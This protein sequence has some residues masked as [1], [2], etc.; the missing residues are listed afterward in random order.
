MDNAETVQIPLIR[1][2]KT[3]GWAGRPLVP[4]TW[5]E[6]YRRLT[7]PPEPPAPPAWINRRVCR[8]RPPLPRLKRKERLNW[9]QWFSDWYSG[10]H[11]L[12]YR[13]RNQGINPNRT[14][15]TARDVINIGVLYM[16]K[17]DQAV[18]LYSSIKALPSAEVPIAWLGKR[19][20]VKT[21]YRIV[22]GRRRD[23]SRGVA[24]LA[25]TTASGI[26]PKFDVK[27]RVE[28]FVDFDG[29]LFEQRPDGLWQETK[30]GYAGGLYAEY[31]NSSDH[32]KSIRP[33]YKPARYDCPTDESTEA[34]TEILGFDLKP[35]YQPITKLL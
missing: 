14:K 5:E 22:Q 21:I 27:D 26:I 19:C 28:F 32:Y 23:P 31:L 11:K 17:G 13:C 12:G 18:F 1:K 10:L 15:I 7:S 35:G 16:Q 2:L 4:E 33:Y 34:K 25:G 30:N 9:H 20:A 24:R 3:S 6:A 8:Q 29:G